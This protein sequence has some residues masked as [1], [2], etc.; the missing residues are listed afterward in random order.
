MFGRFI[1]LNSPAAERP[2]LKQN[3]QNFYFSKYPIFYQPPHIGKCFFKKTTQKSYFCI[4]LTNK[5]FGHLTQYSN[6][7]FYVSKW[8]L[9]EHMKSVTGQCM[10]FRFSMQSFKLNN[11]NSYNVIQFLVEHISGHPSWRHT[12]TNLSSKKIISCHSNQMILAI[13]PDDF[14]L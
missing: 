14:L 7:P 13:I 5:T 8:K 12:F 9:S 1:Y 10:L 2:V 11:S 6:F 4:Y 3:P